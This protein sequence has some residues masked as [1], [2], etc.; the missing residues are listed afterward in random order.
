MTQPPEQYPGQ[1]PQY[2]QQPPPQQ[3][4][5]PQPEYPQQGYPQPAYPQQGYPQ[6]GYPQQGYP[7]PGYPQPGYQPYPQQ[8]KRRPSALW[9][10][11]GA[12]AL[13]LAIVC[14]VVGV[15]TGV[16]MFHTDGYLYADEAAHSFDLGKGSHMLFAEDG[17]A[18][19]TCSV[20]DGSGELALENLDSSSGQ[21][22]IS[23]GGLDWVPFAKFSSDG[24][25]VSVTCTGGPQVRVGA[26]AGETQFVI[27]G[28]SV[29]GAI[30]LGL[31][32]LA[33]LIVVTVLYISRRPKKGLI[34]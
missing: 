9:F 8:P 25:S 16:R 12:I 20:S 33:G 24:S 13:V 1:P 15:I 31:L 5:Y 6:P 22:T 19:P 34:A 21:T 10:I 17:T 26:P 7:Q 11:P 27:L 14:V 29:I 3:Q 23:T 18:A 2:G 30:G 28:I 4:G 32:G